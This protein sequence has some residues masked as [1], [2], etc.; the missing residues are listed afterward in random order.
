MAHIEPKGV[1]DEIHKEH[2]V[3]LLLKM[4][5]KKVNFL[6]YICKA[7]SGVVSAWIVY[8]PYSKRDSMETC[9]IQVSNV[10]CGWAHRGLYVPAFIA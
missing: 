10:S 8:F 1:S 6:S 9:L 7:E 4:I 2:I 5:F 3:Q